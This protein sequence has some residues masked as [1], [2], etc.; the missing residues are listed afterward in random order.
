MKPVSAMVKAAALAAMMGVAAPA[1]AVVTYTFEGLSAFE[2][3][4]FGRFVIS[5]TGPVTSD[6]V[7][8]A[9]QFT[10]C[11]VLSNPDLTCG[12]H[13]F[14]FTTVAEFGVDGNMIEFAANNA[15]GEVGRSF[16]YF[17][18]GAFGANGTYNTIIFG[19]DQAAT[20][21]VSGIGGGGG[22]PPIPEPATWAMLIAG[23]GLTGAAMRRRRVAVGAAVA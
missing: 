11:E 18:P 12:D 19:S 6:S 14:T 9:A 8:P 21:T 22:P 23:F 4:W 15:G 2:G 10:S 3:G 13:R 7:F 5:L 16:F 1:A 20:L 17:Q